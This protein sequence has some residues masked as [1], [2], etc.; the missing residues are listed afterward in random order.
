MQLNESRRRLLAIGGVAL[1]VVLVG[2][3]IFGRENDEDKIRGQ[4]AKL[5]G[6][7][8]VQGD[9]P[10][11]VVRALMLKRE[12]AELFDRDVRVDIPEVSDMRSGRDDLAGLAAQEQRWFSTLDVSFRSI[13]IQL[14][15]ARTSAQVAAIA[16]VQAL[17]NGGT[18]VERDE[19]HI[20]FLFGKDQDGRWLI[21]SLS[22]AVKSVIP[23]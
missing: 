10:N 14:N 18:A 3:A 20:D 4:L 12:F 15:N 22:V 1:G 19:R 23:D 7:I 16:H 2:W 11:L 5:E 6:L 13:D 9:P 8:R 17:R 21:S